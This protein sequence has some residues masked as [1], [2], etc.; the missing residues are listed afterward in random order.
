EWR[1]Q[2]PLVRFHQIGPNFL[3]RQNLHLPPFHLWQLAAPSGVHQNQPLRH[4]LLQAVIQQ[5]MDA[6]N[7]PDA[8]ALVFQ[9]DVLV[10]LYP[11]VLLEIVV[12]PLDLDRGELVQLD[13]PQLGDD[14][15]IDVVQIIV[16]GVFPEP[17][18]GVDLVPHL[19]P[20][21]YRVGAAAIHVQPLTV[22]DGLFQ[23]LLDLRLGLPQDILD[24]LLPG[25]R[26][27]GGRVE[28]LPPA[29]LPFADAALAVGAL[30]PHPS[31][32]LSRQF[33]G[34]LFILIF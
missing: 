3:F 16:L 17:G 18:L 21:F 32:L 31:S 25:R 23:L 30:L 22:C 26:V 2:P 10:S 11:P 7:H 13:V 20:A 34:P 24:L 6:V 33:T 28:P 12:E 14:V 19:H 4:R 15:V 5:G 9:F 8:Q 1:Q 27:I 29:I